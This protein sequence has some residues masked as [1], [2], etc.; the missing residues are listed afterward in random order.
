MHPSSLYGSHG[1]QDGSVEAFTLTNVSELRS[2]EELSDE[3][4]EMEGDGTDEAL[5]A[6]MKQM[7]QEKQMMSLHM[8]AALHL[9]RG[10][11]CF[12]KTASLCLQWYRRTD[13]LA[14][15]KLSHRKTRAY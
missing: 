6:V 3:A 10:G 1:D 2:S 11:G 7:N 12:F 9:Y 5:E 8:P 13:C 15:G 4:A 14:S